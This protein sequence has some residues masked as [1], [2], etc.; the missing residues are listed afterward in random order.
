[1]TGVQTCA[2]PIYHVTY[3]I[4][5]RVFKPHGSGLTARRVHTQIERTVLAEAETARGVVE[6]WRGDTQIEQDSV[7]LR[8]R[9]LRAHERAELGELTLHKMQ[10]SLCLK[11]RAPGRDG[12][13]VTVDRDDFAGVPKPSEDP[14]SMAT[15]SECRVDVESNR[16]QRQGRNHLFDKHRRV[17]IQLP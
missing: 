11:A 14:R 4:Q 5:A 13:R 3:L 16:A 15:A 1:M 12:L 7:A 17:L 8:T 6:L 9:S 2:L 10:S